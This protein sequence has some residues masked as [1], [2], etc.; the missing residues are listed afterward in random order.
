MVNFICSRGT[1]GQ[2]VGGDLQWAL[3]SAIAISVLC[4]MAIAFIAQHAHPHSY[5]EE[6][7]DFVPYH[8]L[9]QSVGLLFG[10]A[11]AC[12]YTRASS[13][14]AAL[15]GLATS[16]LFA[17]ATICFAFAVL[18]FMLWV[19]YVMP[20]ADYKAFLGEVQVED[21]GNKFGQPM[22]GPKAWWPPQSWEA[23]P[24]QEH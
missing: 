16:Q 2:G 7:G 14:A 9:L 1:V 20:Y 24:S 18:I 17:S 13:G 3:G 4:C 19:F 21:F 22:G 15:A 5:S 10:V 12:C 6:A 23:G 8:I 11:W